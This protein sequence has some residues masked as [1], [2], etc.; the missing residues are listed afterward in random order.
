M[1]IKQIIEDT[2]T[3]AGSI[4]DLTIQAL[5]V[6]SLVSFSIETLPGLTEFQRSILRLMEV[7]TVS[8]FT[9]E[10]LLRLAT[11]DKP[12]KFATSFFGI[13]DLIA[14]LPFYLSLGIDLRAVRAFRLLRLF[15]IFKLVRY[16]RAIQRFHSALII[17][18]EEI[19][20]FGVVALMVLYLAAVGIYYCENEAQPEAFASVFHSLWW[21]TT[22]LTTVGYGDVYPVTVGGRCFTFVVLIVG[23]GIVSVPAGL[24][25]SALSKA[26]EIE[27]DETP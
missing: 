15:R 11:A 6:I 10:Y 26:R 16:S 22:T 24:V 9:A 3:S 21:A 17:A 19:V 14:I 4:F 2:D 13:I 1:S 7:V 5:I 25:A 23:L 18:R 20:L 12:M 8:V 27:G